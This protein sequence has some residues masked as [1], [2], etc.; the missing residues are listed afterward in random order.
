MEC[1]AAVMALR[2]S[3]LAL[4]FALAASVSAA[5]R[6]VVLVVSAY[7]PVLALDPLEIRKIFLGLPVLRENRPLRAIRNQ[8]D[9]QLSQV[10]L[11]HVVAMSQ[12]AYDRR[13]LAQVLQQG[14]PRPLELKS[15]EQVIAALSEDPLAVSYMWLK[16]VPVSPRLRVL[17]VLWTD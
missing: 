4:F 17:R 8:S 2:A 5:E 3:L 6:E 16:D 10:F 15:R 9:E 14:R 7:S 11:Q 13:I 1:G 12:S